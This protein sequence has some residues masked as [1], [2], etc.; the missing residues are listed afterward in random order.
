M[1]LPKLL[2]ASRGETV[3]SFV[4]LGAYDGVTFSTTV[5]MERCFGWR[6][7]LIEA[8]SANFDKLRQSPRHATKVH[9]A[10]CADNQSSVELTKSAVYSFT[11]GERAAM[12]DGHR[13]RF[14][15]DRAI[16]T[17]RVPCAPLDRLTGGGAFTFLSLDVE[18]AED[19]VLR[20]SDPRAFAMIMVE[21]DG[22]NLPKERR[23]HRRLLRAGFR[24]SSTLVKASRVYE[25]TPTRRRSSRGVAA[26]AASAPHSSGGGAAAHPLMLPHSRPGYCSVTAGGAGNCS[27]GASGSWPVGVLRGAHRDAVPDVSACLERCARCARCRFLT[28][29]LVDL[30]CSWYARCPETLQ[31]TWAA[32]HHT[33]R[34]LARRRRAWGAAAGHGGLGLDPD[35]AALDSWEEAAAV[36]ERATYG[37]RGLARRD[38]SVR[39]TLGYPA[40]LGH[41]G[42]DVD[43]CSP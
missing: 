43:G 30:E 14:I 41:L 37:R 32:D 5:M 34:M 17:E 25:A 18:G 40:E 15:G 8:S 24:P 38:P 35:Y 27:S 6:G 11:N 39:R 20:S 23:V 33:V 29:S 28:V 42:C 26:S 21:S 3:G 9:S 16:R 22:T 7:V 10:V 36:M 4:E 12:S 19:K 2:R 1:L 13:R 31:T